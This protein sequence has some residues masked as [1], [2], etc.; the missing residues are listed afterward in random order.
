M[1]K[2]YT[3][4]INI[5]ELYYSMLQNPNFRK[6]VKSNEDK[7]IEEIITEYDIKIDLIKEKQCI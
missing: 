4:D 1:G 6:F 7:T 2:D 5:Q 3:L